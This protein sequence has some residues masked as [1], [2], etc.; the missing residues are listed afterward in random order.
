MDTPRFEHGASAL[1]GLVVETAATNAIRNNVIAGGTDGVIGSGGSNPTNWGA[2]AVAG[3]TIERV[4]TGTEDGLNYIDLR[5][6]GTNAM[7]S[8]QFSGVYFDSNTGIVAASGQAWNVSFYA[9]VV[10]G[11][12]SSGLEP[13]AALVERTAAGASLAFNEEALFMASTRERFG[14][15]ATLSSGSTARVQPG[16]CLRIASGTTL[17]VTFRIYS[18]QAAQ[19]AFTTSLIPTSGAPAN[20]AADQV[21]VAIADGT[22]N[23]RIGTKYV[24]YDIL[25]VVVAGGAGWDFAWP[26]AAVTASQRFAKTVIFTTGA[27]PPDPFLLEWS[28]PAQTAP[29][30]E[31]VGAAT[32]YGPYGDNEDV[33][34]IMP[35][36]IKTTQLQ[37]D[38]GRHV[39]VIGGHL[40]P[41][42]VPSG[43]FVM[44]IANI[45]GS[46]FVEGMILD[47]ALVS[48]DGFNVWG[49]NGF[50]PDVYLQNMRI[51]NVNGSYAGVHA[52]I[53]QHQDD[54]G[55]LTVHR[56]TGP[57]HYQ[58]FF[59]PP[60]LSIASTT[61]K[62][63]N[64]SFQTN[65]LHTGTY[66]LW[67]RD[68][69]AQAPYAVSLWEV[70]I[71]P[72]AGQDIAQH[73][74]WPSSAQTGCAAT[75]TGSY[76]SWPPEALVSGVVTEG[77]PL[78][79][80]FVPAGA[81]VGADYISPGYR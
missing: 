3:V 59:I 39:R 6:S 31:I 21:H 4:G 9:K 64:L 23:I 81:N 17:D 11:T 22:Y 76:V 13:R 70:Y 45:T 47:A 58:G 79:G 10:A 60:Q 34:L 61:F 74:V 78:T 67:F 80:D 1:E 43:N 20:R 44:R 26:V 69:C 75:K 52:D 24:N 15:T 71:S 49:K 56:L 14:Y 50:A 53:F 63:V 18:P 66:L 46:A 19:S 72:R 30:V 8:A 41:A 33:L 40:R 5:Y 51:E 2:I 42:A 77:A 12:L 57:S 7:G 37:V 25:N 55:Q 48:A 62:Q 36:T 73:G 29:R 27:L 16:F 35:S 38:G 28:P 65:P 54:I 68:N 32:Y